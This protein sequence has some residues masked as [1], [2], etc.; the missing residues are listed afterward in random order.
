MY[1][2]IYANWNG[3]PYQIGFY[4]GEIGA[5][6]MSVAGGVFGGEGIGAEGAVDASDVAETSYVKSSTA[7][8]TYWP[9]NDGF[10]GEASPK[11]FQA[12]EMF[13]RYGYSGGTF[14]APV[15]TPAEMRA[16]EPGTL[17]KPYNVYKVLQPFDGLEGQTA[18]WFGQTGL[19]TQYKFSSS[20][21]DLLDQGYIRKV[22]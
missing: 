11:T 22:N 8:K 3:A 14:G 10:L 19:G 12:G 2:G 17:S 13:D 6:F 1:S 5:L 9:P 15:G 4:G 16:L 21:Q 20:I 7:L 18:P